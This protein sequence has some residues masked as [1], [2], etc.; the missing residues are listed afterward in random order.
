[1]GIIRN[2]SGIN[3]PETFI[4]VWRFVN[5]NPGAF[6]S[7]SP[8]NTLSHLS[9]TSLLFFPSKDT[10]C[11]LKAPRTSVSFLPPQH[12]PPRPSLFT[13]SLGFGN[14]LFSWMVQ[15]KHSNLSHLFTQGYLWPTRKLCSVVPWEFIRKTRRGF[16]ERLGSHSARFAYII[17][18]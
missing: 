9:S 2:Q 5:Q 18:F 7:G 14:L 8:L 10:Y 13:S 11:P 16:I 12:F 1:M 3:K 4:T 6:P 15:M 17:F